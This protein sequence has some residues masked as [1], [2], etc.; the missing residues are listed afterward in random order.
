[1]QPSN[2]SNNNNNSTTFNSTS[3]RPQLP[4]PTPAASP[5]SSTTRFCSRYSFPLFVVGLFVV[6][7][8]PKL[9]LYFTFFIT[10]TVTQVAVFVVN[11]M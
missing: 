2:N 4:Q 6:L 10:T 8:C 1:M 5:K 11:V 3:Y 7:C 9:T